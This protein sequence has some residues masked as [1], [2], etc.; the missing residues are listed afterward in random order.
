M[1]DFSQQSRGTTRQ[2]SALCYF[3]LCFGRSDSISN[4]DNEIANRSTNTIHIQTNDLKLNDEGDIDWIEPEKQIA[5]GL[6]EDE[7][8]YEYFTKHVY[9]IASQLVPTRP[10]IE[11]FKSFC[12]RRHEWV[13]EGST[14][15]EKLQIDPKSALLIG[16]DKK[17]NVLIRMEKRAFM[18]NTTVED[19][20]SWLYDMEPIELAKAFEK[21]ENKKARA[22]Y[23]VHIIHYTINTYCT[24]GFEERMH[25]VD[26]LE[27][28]VSG[29]T[30]FAYQQKRAALCAGGQPYDHVGFCRFQSS[31]QPKIHGHHI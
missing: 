7:I 31:S 14:G 28:G 2:I 23:G 30:E 21:F 15:G 10:V 19:M 12:E 17:K 20:L 25:F 13:V 1:F 5:A 6:E 27:K 16:H 22:I 29:M 11:D 26:G 4:W 3:E 8:F 18:E 9:D 24:F